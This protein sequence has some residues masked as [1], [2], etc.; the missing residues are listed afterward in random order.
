MLG[1]S[2][3]LKASV[4]C[5][6]R[7]L[8]ALPVREDEEDGWISS[9]TRPPLPV[10]CS[11]R[12]QSDAEKTL[13]VRS[14]CVADHLLF[15]GMY[16]TV[17]HGWC[18]HIVTTCACLLVSLN[19]NAHHLHHLQV[20]VIECDCMV[21]YFVAF[22][23]FSCSGSGF[24]RQSVKTWWSHTISAQC[25]VTTAWLQSLCSPMLSLAEHGHA[26]GTFILN[27]LVSTTV[28]TVSVDHPP[29]ASY[30]RAWYVV[31]V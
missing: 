28:T 12:S 2:N 23:Y 15:G 10:R 14:Q 1:S 16:V 25:W 24:G 9:T 21:K 3:P 5:K 27:M 31:C 11:S 22:W 26:C 4:R 8:W 30:Q 18:W 20:S 19:W 13:C 7:F 6:G 29:Q 17:L